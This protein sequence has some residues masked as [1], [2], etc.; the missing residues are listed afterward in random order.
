MAIGEKNIND[1]E[2]GENPDFVDNNGYSE[3]LIEDI[4]DEYFFGKI[5]PD[6]S[7]SENSSSVDNST[8]LSENADPVR[9]FDSENSKE[10]DENLKSVDSLELGVRAD[11]GDVRRN[12]EWV[13]FMICP[14][15]VWHDK[16]SGENLTIE[17]IS[18]DLSNLRYSIKFAEKPEAEQFG[19]LDNISKYGTRNQIANKF[20]NLSYSSGPDPKQK[21]VSIGLFEEKPK[22]DAPVLSENSDGIITKA[23]PEKEPKDAEEP[24]SDSSNF[25]DV[26]PSVT[27]NTSSKWFEK[28]AERMSLEILNDIKEEKEIVNSIVL[29]YE[30]KAITLH[31]NDEYE[32]KING[33]HSVIK[34]IKKDKDGNIEIEFNNVAKATTHSVKKWVECFTKYMKKVEQNESIGV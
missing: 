26:V 29:E 12:Q 15:Q 28:P 7:E 10:S 6:I 4:P 11:T 24:D 13:K 32:S 18:H 31:V 9:S 1:R 8:V 2:K 14:G 30:G 20:K 21:K 16:S 17:S 33:I 19:S 5:D 27:D 22:D 3:L 23:D 25:G 34:S